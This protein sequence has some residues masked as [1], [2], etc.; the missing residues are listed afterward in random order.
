MK[1]LKLCEF[2]INDKLVELGRVY[3][4]FKVEGGRVF[5]KPVFKIKES[6]GLFASIPEENVRKTNIR[7]PITR[8]RMQELLKLIAKKRKPELEAI[9]VMVAKEKLNSNRPIDAVKVLKSLWKEMHDESVNTTKSRRDVFDLAVEKLAE[10][11]ALVGRTKL[12]TAREKIKRS[13]PP[14]KTAS[15]GA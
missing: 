8:K 12:A 2:K 15:P 7:K 4:I 11:F 1:K 9:D 6:N 13:L 5:F 3:N 10:E 14:L